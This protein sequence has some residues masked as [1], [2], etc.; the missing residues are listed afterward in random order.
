MGGHIQQQ[1]LLTNGRTHHELVQ[2][3]DCIHRQLMLTADY[4]CTQ[5]PHI[6]GRTYHKLFQRA[7]KVHYQL[8]MANSFPS[9]YGRQE[10]TQPV[11]VDGGYHGTK[12]QDV[13]LVTMGNE[14]LSDVSRD[15]SP[16]ANADGGYSPAKEGTKEQ[17][18]S[19]NHPRGSGDRS[20][21]VHY[22]L[23]TAGLPS[24]GYRQED[25]PPTTILDGG[26]HG[27]KEEGE[28]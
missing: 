27:A 8:L 7:G 28:E 21:R 24:S 5:G 20:H 10:V 4:A 3:V 23:L 15:V 16:P 2:S 1:L 13:S 22:Q 12:E 18:L 25:V 14:M 9:H 11:N 6:E 19:H 17:E 26:Q